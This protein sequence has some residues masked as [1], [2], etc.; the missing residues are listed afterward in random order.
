MRTEKIIKDEPLHPGYLDCC[1]ERLHLMINAT[2]HRHKLKS[3]LVIR[4]YGIYGTDACL[5]GNKWLS[6]EVCKEQSDKAVK[7]LSQWGIPVFE[8]NPAAFHAPK[9]AGFVSLV[10]ADALL[11]GD[12]FIRFGCGSFQDRLVKKFIYK[13]SNETDPKARCY[14]VCPCLRGIESVHGLDIMDPKCPMN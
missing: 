3:V 6:T 12:V 9:N 13:Y 10:E 7:R 4:D 2:I 1:T 11:Q 5:Y 14:S 8:F